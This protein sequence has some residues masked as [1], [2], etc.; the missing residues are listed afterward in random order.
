VAVLKAVLEDLIKSGELTLIEPNGRRTTFG[1]GNGMHVVARVC[2]SFTPFKLALRPDLYLGEAY[3][4]GS[5]RI[6][7]GTLWDLLDLIG[8]NLARRGRGSD[9]F[10]RRTVKFLARQL[11]QMNSPRAA[12][13]NVAHHYDLPVEMYRSFLDHDMQYSCGYF[14][15]ETVSL[16]EAQAAKKN[17]IIAKLLLEPGQRILDIGCGWGGLALSMARRED[18]EVVGVT[19]SKEQ[20]EVARERARIAG[21]GTRVTFELRDYREI[22]DRFDRIVSVGMFEHVGV[23]HY[24]AFFDCISRLLHDDGVALI[25]AI[26]RATGPDV[27]SAWMRKYIFPGGYIPALSQIWPAIERAG[28]WVTDLEILRLHYADTLRAWRHRFLTRAEKCDGRFRR[29]WE[30]YLAVSEMSFRYGG[31]MVFQAQLTRTVDALPRTRDYMFEYERRRDFL[32][33]AE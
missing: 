9:G 20:L 19:L 28:F 23:A 11:H 8:R 27:T 31:M 1:D 6:E 32:R 10:C 33:A 7:Q 29:L 25:H 4:D 21:L 13:R 26:G 17:H 12:R 16:D 30:F 14:A 3:M 5:L 15:D 22:K 2:G 18:V 24:D